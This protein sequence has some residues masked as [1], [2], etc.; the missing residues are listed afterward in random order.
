MEV[1]KQLIWDISNFC[2]ETKLMS[3]SVTMQYILLNL[4]MSI[5]EC[6]HLYL[7]LHWPQKSNS[8]DRDYT[9]SDT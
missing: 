7:G 2:L 9:Y 1:R 4:S 3:T 5:Y 8:S 6:R